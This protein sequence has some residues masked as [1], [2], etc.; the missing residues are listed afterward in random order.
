MQRTYTKT[1]G[2]E[3]LIGYQIEKLG[4]NCHWIHHGICSIGFQVPRTARE[5]QSDVATATNIL[6]L[7]DHQRKVKAY[8]SNIPL[9][10]PV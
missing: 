2:Q 7:W 5:T 6:S 10:V 4:H 1:P 3:S 9:L 8:T